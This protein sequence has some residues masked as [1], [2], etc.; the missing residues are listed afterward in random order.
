MI[1][2]KRLLLRTWRSS[3]RAGFAELN[4]DER[5]MEFLGG[6]VSPAESNAALDRIQEH[7]EKHGF[8]RMAIESRANGEFVGAIGPAVVPFETHFT[9]SIEIGWRLAFEQWGR[10]LATEAAR[11]VL[12]HCHQTLGFKEIVAFTVP[13]NF[14]SRR[15]MEKCGMIHDLAGDFDHPD[16]PEGHPLRRHVLYRFHG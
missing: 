13:A 1:E 8:G 12:R 10:G 7:F 3:D 15:V 16:L 11:G 2:T 14:R 4:R 6:P 5:V 9:P